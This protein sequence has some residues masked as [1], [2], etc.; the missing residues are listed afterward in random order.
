MKKKL[1]KSQDKVV[2]GVFG[3]IAEYFDWDKTWVRLAGIFLI[4]FPGSVI[5]GIFMYFIAAIIMPERPATNHDDETVIEGEF[6]EK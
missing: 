4:I 6:R 5:P 1:Y 2:S 3:G